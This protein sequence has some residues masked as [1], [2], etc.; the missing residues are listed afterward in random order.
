VPRA[1]WR[2]QARKR[3]EEEGGGGVEEKEERC[4]VRP[5]DWR[6]R[7]TAPS[8]GRSGRTAA[9][10][11]VVRGGSPQLLLLRFSEH[12]SEWRPSVELHQPLKQRRHEAHD[13]SVVYATPAHTPSYGL[14]ESA[15]GVQ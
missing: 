6:R 13:A 1:W 11:G 3:R 10:A 2:P 15:R 12:H 7:E 14:A 8:W 9:R 5:Q 4:G